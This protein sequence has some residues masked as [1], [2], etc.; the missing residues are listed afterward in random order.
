[1][2]V[3]VSEPT[4]ETTPE[5]GSRSLGLFWAVPVIVF[6]AIQL[7]LALNVEA[8]EY[9]EAIFLNV[10][11]NLRDGDGLVRSLSGTVHYLEHTPLYP[12]LLAGVSALLGES[13]TLLRFVTSAAGLGGVVLV[14]A[15]V[16]RRGG[17]WAGLIAA[18]LLATSPMWTVFSHIIYMEVFM[19]VALVVAA[20]LLCRDTSEIRSWWLASLKPSRKSVRRSPA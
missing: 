3:Q 19:A 5:A 8:I 7:F 9:D 17:Q 6:V 14:F 4:Q 2:V 18:L 11:G 16:R 12:V 10:A 13:V 1:M 15:A 20:Y